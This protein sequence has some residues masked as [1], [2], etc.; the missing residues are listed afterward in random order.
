MTARAGLAVQSDKT[1]ADYERLA[2]AAEQH[3][4]DVLSVYG[5]LWFQPPIV[6]LMAMARATSRVTLGPACLSPFVVHPIDIAAQIAALDAASAGRAYLGLSRGGW[7]GELGVTRRGS[8]QGVLEA[9]RVAG[10]LLAGDT[11]GI[12]GVRFAL[13]PGA[14]LR[15]GLP[16]RRVPLLVGTWGRRLATAA[17]AL[18]DEVKVGGSA[19]PSMVR[20]LRGWVLEGAADDGTAPRAEPRQVGLVAGAVTVV[21][22][23]G[24]AAR[25]RA[26][27]EV[28]MYLDVVGAFD[29]TVQLPAGLLEALHARLAARDTAAAASLIP[30]EVLDCFAFAGSPEAVARHAA[31]VVEAGADRVEFGTPHGLSARAGIEL[32]GS[33]VLP[34]L[35]EAR[36]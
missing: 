19:N 32:L 15:D 28:A 4:F 33:R 1:L 26:R 3:G 34:A 29:Q 24:R 22:E 20:L 18:A 8:M 13:A 10:A 12:P 7:L 31:A 17:G 6:A 21:D 9:A 25:R 11:G 2:A 35:R 5:D 16:R 30:D 27:E 23:D 36:P 14:R